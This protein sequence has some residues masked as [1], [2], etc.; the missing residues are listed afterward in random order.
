MHAAAPPALTASPPALS[1][2]RIASLRASA[3]HSESGGKKKSWKKWL[4]AAAAAAAIA[5]VGV[6]VYL[7]RK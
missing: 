1:A 7:R 6:I 3:R 5:A 4:P 2:A